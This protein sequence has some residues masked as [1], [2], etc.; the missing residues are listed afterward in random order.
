ML[1]RSPKQ[2]L[3]AALVIAVT[4]LVLWWMLSRKEPQFAGRPA[5]NYVRS[6]LSSNSVNSTEVTTQLMSMDATVAVTAITRVMMREDIY[7]KLRYQSLYPKLPGWLRKQLAAPTIDQ[8]LAFRCGMAL[9]LFGPAAEP[10]VPTLIQATKRPKSNVAQAA[11]QTLVLFA[12]NTNIAR[13]V[14]ITAAQAVIERGSVNESWAMME[15]LPQ[16][17]PEAGDAVPLLISALSKASERIRGKAAITLGLLGP[18]AKDAAPA[19]RR[20][21]TDEWLNVRE[22]ATNALIAI[23]SGTP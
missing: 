8:N 1:N 22:A 17:I 10:S 2:L 20:V 5:S 15:L 23:E 13:S 4:A 9:S 19:L 21:L 11:I 14:R 18:L 16:T 3:S 6:V 7:W 12:Q